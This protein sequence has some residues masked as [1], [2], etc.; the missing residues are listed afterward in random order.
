MYLPAGMRLPMFGAMHVDAAAGHERQQ[1]RRAGQPNSPERQRLAQ[2]RLAGDDQP[3]LRVERGA[4]R[5][6]DEVDAGVVHDRPVPRPQL[7]DLA[8][9]DPRSNGTFV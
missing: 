6:I 3:A 7:D 5:Q 2:C 8:R 4:L 9:S 1:L